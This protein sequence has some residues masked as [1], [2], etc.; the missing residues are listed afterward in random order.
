MKEL[1][2]NLWRNKPL[3]IAVLAGIALFFYIIYKHGPGTPATGTSTV[4]T[5]TGTY[6]EGTIPVPGSPGPQGPPGIPGLPGPPGPPGIPGLPGPKEPPTPGGP[7][8]PHDHDGGNLRVYGHAG[9]LES[10]PHVPIFRNGQKVMVPVGSLVTWDGHTIRNV[11]GK[12]YF[13]VSWNGMQGWLGGDV[14]Q[15]LKGFPE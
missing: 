4:P 7:K 1:W 9:A 13:W 5:S 2:Q 15:T 3:L 14:L 6:V 10:S 11:A 8:P 12:G